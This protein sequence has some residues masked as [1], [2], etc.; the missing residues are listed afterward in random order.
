[1]PARVNGINPSL[2]HHGEMNSSDLV[3]RPDSGRVFS[4]ERRVRLGD[5]DATGEL[6]LDGM[7]RYLQDVSRDDSSDSGLANAL[8]WV[9]RST[10]IEVVNAPRFEE[11]LSL[12]TWCSGIGGRWAERRI[13]MRGERGGQVE[14][15][16][17]WVYVDAETGR[18]ARLGSDFHELYGESAQGRKASVRGKLPSQVPADVAVAPWSLRASDFDVL[19]HVNNA[20]HWTPVEQVL[21]NLAATRSDLRADIEFGV[22][23]VIDAR[24]GWRIQNGA[25]ESWLVTGDGPDQAT[26]S[27]VRVTRTG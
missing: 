6:R 3:H 18:P 20:A 2:L 12:D 13:S 24:H 25:L 17:V 19:G 5:V 27:V 8:S 1:M 14:A 7:A 11:W 21:P 15:A 4:A 16:T 22:E 10:T 9:V 26:T 23:L